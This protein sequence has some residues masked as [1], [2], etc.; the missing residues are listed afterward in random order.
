MSGET[1][2]NNN[3]EAEGN[4]TISRGKVRLYDLLSN[5]KEEKRKDRNNNIILSIAAVSAVTV[6]G[7]IL[8]I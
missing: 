1:R 5:L 8:S 6:F 7:I 3:Q 2:F 4:E